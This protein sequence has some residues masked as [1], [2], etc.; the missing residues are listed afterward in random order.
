MKKVL[1]LLLAMVMIVMSFAGCGEKKAS[2]IG[3]GTELS[4]FMHFYGTVFDD[5]W[6]VF[7]K[8][9]ELTG[10][11]LTGTASTV[12][13]DS[14][15]AYNNML[16]EGK[17][18]DIIHYFG[19][20]LTDLGLEGGVIPLEDLIEE[21]AP[22][23]QKFFEDCPEAKRRA[24]ASDGHIYYIPGSL[25]GI[26]KAA[27]PSQG[28]FIRQDWLDKLGLKTPT[29]VDEF[30]EVMT[31]FRNGDPNGNGIKDEVP[32]FHRS[33]IGFLYPLFGLNNGWY[34]KDGVV[35]L[36]SVEENY[37]EAIINIRKW[38]KEGI[39]DKE[40]FTRGGQAREQLLSTNLGGCTHDWFSSTGGYNSLY[41]ESVNGL[42]FVAMA[43]PADVNG[44]QIEMCSRNL[45][46]D[47]GWGI[48][49]DNENIEETMKYF[50]FWFT[51]EGQDLRSFG[52]EGIHYNVVDGEKQF[53][54][55]VLKSEEGAV[56]YLKTQGANLELPT[57]GNLEAEL[58]GMNEI[59][60]A[61]FEMYDNGGFVIQQFAN[62]K[63]TDEEQKI[64]NKYY[65]DIDTYIDEMEQKWILGVE[66][67][68]KGWDKYLA[69][70]KKMNVDQV[71]KIYQTAY[72]RDNK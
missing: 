56:N 43:P 30:Y 17:L 68:E 67:I 11:S 24:T 69:T 28:W 54:D 51:Q 57:I 38:Y 5:E 20:D 15:A 22:N 66:D 21:Y 53:T 14:S 35:T 26:D 44:N 58:R 19:T 55:A 52:V 9:A 65:N 42:N 72:A 63:F 4:I 39:L 46:H 64:L 16:V 7:Q 32:V 41:S 48:S 62:P 50:D 45:L 18:P 71:I 47:L 29:N 27:V 60:R 13:T 33:S 37:K 49:K 70:L 3:D 23:I 12:Q 8:A 40:I 36:G 59:A 31:T 2:K 10:V 1:V 61:G 34:L 25:S 6:P